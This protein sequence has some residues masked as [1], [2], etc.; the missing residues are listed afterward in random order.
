MRRF[1]RWINQK[2]FSKQL[3]LRVRLFNV[4]A[5]AGTLVSLVFTVFNSIAKSPVN[6]ASCFLGAC[7]A[8]ALLVY[9]TRTRRYQ[10][11]YMITVIGVF[12]ILFP[13]MFFTAGGYRYG[14]ISYFTFAIAFTIFMLEGKK[15]L[16][17]AGLELSV[18]IALCFYAHAH[19]ERIGYFET[20]PDTFWGVLTCFF[21]ASVALGIAM[22]LHFKL[23]N[24][25]Q[26]ELE[27]ARQKLTRRTPC[28]SA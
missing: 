8:S 25:Q 1:F 26:R 17:L 23:Y 13:V 19:P 18:Y 5:M 21:T 16:L 11:A 9:A 10:L 15:S 3:D 28:L 6:I 7:L 4:L 27:Q 2:F 24:E 22:F 12:L 14:M 20:N